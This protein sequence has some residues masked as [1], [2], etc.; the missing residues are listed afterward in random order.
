MP[1]VPSP[2]HALVT[3]A[4]SPLPETYGYPGIIEVTDPVQHLLFSGT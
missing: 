3:D 1:H 2:I 4:L